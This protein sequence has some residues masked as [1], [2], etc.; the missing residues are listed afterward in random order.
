V[1]FGVGLFVGL[2]VT[3]LALAMSG[4]G[5]G[6]GSPLLSSV[7]IVGAPLAGLA[8]SLRKRRGGFLI[9]SAVLVGA[10]GFDLML[11][12]AT[13]NEG[14]SYLA[15]VWRNGASLVLIWAVMFASWQM[16]AAI[17]VLARFRDRN[18]A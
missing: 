1:S 17:V 12:R 7:S 14:T 18:A 6:W 4:F 16:V 3:A 5:H 13:L 10:L 15:R 11:W 8:W 9:A 2:G